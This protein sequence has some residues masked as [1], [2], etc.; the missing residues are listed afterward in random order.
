MADHHQSETILGNLASLI[1]SGGIKI[2]DLT[3]TLTP[4]YPIIQ[5]PAEFNQASPFVKEEISRY[6]E[7]GPAWY[8]NNFTLSEHT[9]THFDAPI[10]WITGKEDPWPHSVRRLGVHA[11]RLAQ[12]CGPQKLD[13][14]EGRWCAFAGPR[15]RLCAVDD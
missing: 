12:G 2:V 3:E 6:D 11:H 8:W 7:R 14:Y 1:S 15:Y 13:Q 10:H 5:L 4:E 9:G